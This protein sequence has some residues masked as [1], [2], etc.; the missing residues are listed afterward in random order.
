M[1]KNNNC[2]L[3]KTLN[4][5]VGRWGEGAVKIPL[6]QL[7]HDTSQN[8]TLYKSSFQ[9]NRMEYHTITQSKFF[10]LRIRAV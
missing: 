2:G 9:Y 10:M 3:K 7:S 5:G 8:K 6:Q 1:G 4:G